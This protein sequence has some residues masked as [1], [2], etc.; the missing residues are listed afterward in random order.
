VKKIAQYVAQSFR[1]K[2]NAKLLPWR[3]VARKLWLLLCLSKEV[4][5]RL[6]GEKSANLVT[7][8]ETVISRG[9]ALPSGSTGKGGH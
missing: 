8:I 7:L 5:N 3:K 9:G 1:K 4:N 6:M 2:K